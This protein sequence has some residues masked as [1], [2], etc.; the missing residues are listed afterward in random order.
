MAAPLLYAQAGQVNAVVPFGIAGPAT[1]IMVETSEGSYGPIE[2]PVDAAVPGIFAGAILNQDYSV[3]SPSNP[4][5]R[6]SVVVIYATGAG[7]MTPAMADGAFAPVSLPL[8][9][10]ALG[11]S[12]L[13]GGQT[14][15]VE[16]AG[17]APAMVAGVIQVNARVPDQVTPG[18]QLP[19]MLYVGNYSSQ[20]GAT[21]AVR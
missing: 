7:Q 1:R 3:N 14:A 15:N 4:A 18:D 20:L 9:I 19:I 6:G 5:R 21:V 8:P 12:V 2:L 11:V 13:I 17:A 10:P 16:Y